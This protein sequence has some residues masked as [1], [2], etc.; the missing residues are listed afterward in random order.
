[1]AAGNGKQSDSI[2]KINGDLAFQSEQY[3]QAI[4][5]YSLALSSLEE[6]ESGSDDHQQKKILFSNRSAAYSMTGQYHSAL[7]D[8][9]TVIELDPHWPKGYFRAAK[10]FS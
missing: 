2:E 1:M 8:A 6:K 9:Q 3:L 5:W 10:V 4:T 7:I